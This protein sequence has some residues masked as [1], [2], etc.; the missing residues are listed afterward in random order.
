MQKTPLWQYKAFQNWVKTILISEM[1]DEKDMVADFYCNGMDTGKWERSKIHCYYGFDPSPEE[2]SIAES[3]LKQKKNP[4]SA[5][6]LKCN[7]NEDQIDTIIK[8]DTNQIIG[9]DVDNNN[10]NTRNNNYNNSFNIDQNGINNSSG[11]I[12]DVV[13]CF[14]G[15]QNSFSSAQDAE[16]LI[17][18][19]SVLLK[20]GGFFFG[21]IPDSSSIWYRSQKVSS[22]FPGVKSAL[23]TIEFNS[24]ISNFF[25]CKYKLTLKDGSI[26]EEN[27]IHFPS[28][29]NICKKYN[30]TLV[31][32]INFTDFYD[33]NKKTYEKLLKN[34]GVLPQGIKKIDQP[35]MELIGLYT[36]FIFVKEKPEI[37]MVQIK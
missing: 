1:V 23:Y 34:S 13:S 32:A 4:Y 12:F 6:F 9:M 37:K 36:T 24:E 35:Q 26:I 18:N 7:F 2:L 14:N 5:K 3:K 30:L 16:Q 20:D 11:V 21:I 28:F 10:N 19:V 17:K 25:G 31:E 27:L 33:E 15:V 22:G 8:N 29:I